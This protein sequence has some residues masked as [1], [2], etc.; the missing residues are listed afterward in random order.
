LPIIALAL[1]AL[2]TPIADTGADKMHVCAA[3][4]QA[5]TADQRAT[6]TYGDFM[7]ICT[8]TEPLAPPGATARCRDGTYSMNVA[9]LGR[10]AAHGGVARAF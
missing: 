3:R 6:M 10:C 9:P 5:A 8:K 4:W 1:A 7:A 2:M